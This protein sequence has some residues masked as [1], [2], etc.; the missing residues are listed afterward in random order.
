MAIYPMYQTYGQLC[1]SLYYATG[2]TRLYRNIGIVFLV[3]G[4]P[5]LYVLVAPSDRGG[6]G[7]AASGLAL[8]TVLLSI[9][10][11]HGLLWFSARQLGLK[12][13]WF[14]RFQ[15]QVV[16]ILLAAALL[17]SRAVSGLGLERVPDLLLS[18]A[19]Y[20]AIALAVFLVRPEW[21]GIERADVRA[22]LSVLHLQRA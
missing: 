14:V 10:S 22:F 3:S 8:K 16:A 17:S 18:G 2:Q 11:V 5:L 1:G 12:F 13:H 19:V 4:V 21:L 6:F 20:S 9:L 15:L 7:M